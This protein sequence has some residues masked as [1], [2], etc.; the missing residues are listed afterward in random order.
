MKVETVEVEF[1][2][3]KWGWHLSVKLLVEENPGTW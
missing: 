3:G 1:M 2:E